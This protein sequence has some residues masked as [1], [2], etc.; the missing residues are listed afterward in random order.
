MAL[1][2]CLLGNPLETLI[3][4][5]IQS[6]FPCTLVFKNLWLSIV[7]QGLIFSHGYVIEINFID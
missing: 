5:K 7:N 1:Y 6:I 2:Y 4:N 3:I